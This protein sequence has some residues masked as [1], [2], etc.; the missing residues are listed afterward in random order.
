MEWL[1]ETI[2]PVHTQ[3]LGWFEERWPAKVGE[4]WRTAH[5]WRL[6]VKACVLSTEKRPSGQ[7]NL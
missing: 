2:D 1:V 6:E 3:K 5:L 7:E 4:I